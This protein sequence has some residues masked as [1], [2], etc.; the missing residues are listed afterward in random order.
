MQLQQRALTTASPYLRRDFSSTTVSET[1]PSTPLIENQLVFA[2]GV[3][4]IELAFQRPLATLRQSGDLDQQGNAHPYTELQIAT[5]LVKD[6]N[7]MEGEKY[8]DAARRCV[9]CNFDV[10]DC[11]LDNLEFQDQFY[12]GVVLPLQELRRALD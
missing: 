4:L 12:K 3:M 6:L 1:K 2:L 5:R 9:K 11:S 7:S 8:S 10:Q